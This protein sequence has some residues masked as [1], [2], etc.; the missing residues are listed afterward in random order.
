MSTISD[1]F[2]HHRGASP[3]LQPAGHMRTAIFMVINLA[4]FVTVNALWR[5][6]STGSWFDFSPQ[7]YQQDLATPLAD[8]LVYP[9]NIF[10]HPWMIPVIA[11]M[12]AMIVFTPIIMAILYRLLYSGLFI[13][14]IVLVGHA[15]LLALTMGLAC[16]L[17]GRTRFRSDMPFLAAI[18]A[19][20]PVGVY[21]YFFA[22]LAA[23]TAA[24]LPMQKLVLAAPLIGAA[25]V[26]V[27]VFAFVLW[28]ARLAKYRPGFLAPVLVVL[29]TIPPV[30]FHLRIGAD[31]LE[32]SLITSRLAEGDAVF[33]PMAMETWSRTRGA[34]GLNPQTLKDCVKDDLQSRQQE[35]IGRCEKFLA[36]HGSSSRRSSILWVLAQAKSL[37]LDDTALEIGLVKYTAA[38]PHEDSEDSWRRLLADGGESP[39]SALARWRLGVLAMRRKNV[40][41]ALDLLMAAHKELDKMVEHNP[42]RLEA[43]RTEE[44]FSP[45]ASVPSS[46]YY[47]EADFSVKK[48]LWLIQVNDVTRDDS[49][50][51]ALAAYLAVDPAKAGYFDQLGALAGKYERTRLGDNLKL[52]FALANPNLYERAEALILLANKPGSDAAVEAN[53]ELGR[54]TMQTSQAPALPLVEGLKGPREYLELVKQAGDNP[55][56]PI[57][58]QRLAMLRIATAPA[59]E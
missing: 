38:F 16:A 54:L 31:E 42:A 51:E 19:L 13:A 39:H 18:I 35:L 17:A 12:L 25:V 24:A 55:W 29:L 10:T 33:E 34:E 1:N 50:V 44:I 37:E 2:D 32:Y 30:I 43:T 8:T 28:L 58:E 47:A 40:A 49:S 46:R 45:A 6:L 11:L 27:I 7:A 21:L 36:R 59:G 26:A 41:E 22:F 5:Y 20:L 3:L 4:C 53:Y 48:L 14:A 9:L 23:D 56:L 52:A 57:A 15:P